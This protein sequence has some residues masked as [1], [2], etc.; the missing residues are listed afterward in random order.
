MTC[1]VPVKMIQQHENPSI[2]LAVFLLFCHTD[3]EKIEVE[4]AATTYL[5]LNNF[6]NELNLVENPKRILIWT[7][8]VFRLEIKFSTVNSPK[9][10]WNGKKIVAFVYALWVF[11]VGVASAKWPSS[12][13]L[14]C[15][16]K[17][18]RSISICFELRKNEF[19]PTKIFF[20][21]KWMLQ[22]IGRKRKKSGW[23]TINAHFIVLVK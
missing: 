8:P 9:E 7:N 13:H 15:R 12:I 2:H 1:C 3:E 18:I 11:C 22:I 6:Q 19:K 17:S 14:E 5:I 20:R 16:N 10:L 21:L 23:T 4:K